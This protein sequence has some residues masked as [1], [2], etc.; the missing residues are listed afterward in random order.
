M[1]VVLYECVTCGLVSLF[2]RTQ[3]QRV[4]SG[5][6]LQRTLNKGH[7]CNED[8]DCSTDHIQLCIKSPSELGTPLNTGQQAGSRW[9][10]LYGGSTVVA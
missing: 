9:C 4:Y 2:M 1:T 8:T 3:V 10:P 7:L 6:S 5:T